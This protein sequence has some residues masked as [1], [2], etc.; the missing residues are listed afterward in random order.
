VQA[1]GDVTK[2]HRIRKYFA[3][4]V[5]YDSGTVT[6]LAGATDYSLTATIIRESSTVVRCMVQAMTTSAT[7]TTPVTYT[8]ITG[9]TLSGTNIIK[10]TGV[11]GGAGV[12]VGDIINKLEKIEWKSAD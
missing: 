6:N 9:L 12:A 8:R 2:T 4:T 7:A 3:G 5:I 11:A 1:V 10:T